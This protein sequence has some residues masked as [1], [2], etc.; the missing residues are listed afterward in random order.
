MRFFLTGAT[1]YVGSRVLRRLSATG[2]QVKALVRPRAGGPQLENLPAV[3]YVT[4]DLR[5]RDAI[6]SSG[7]WSDAVI[8]T[9]AEHDGDMSG[10][11]AAFIAA[12]TEALSWSG[13]ALV[14]TSASVVYGDTGDAPREENGPIGSPL[15]SRAWR[16]EHDNRVESLISEGIRSSVIRPST[17]Y[18]YGEGIVRS[19]IEHA[20]HNGRA[21]YVDEGT[22][23]FSTVHI[24]DLIDAY[25]GV[26]EH[27][28]AAGVFNVAS[29]EILSR[30][31]FAELISDVLRSSIKPE[32]VTLSAAIAE[33]GELAAIGSINQ[34]L[35]ATKIKRCL[36]WHP[37]RP[38]LESEL[39]TGTYAN[40]TLASL[41]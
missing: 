19:R 23:L 38:T 40:L 6:V 20:A 17:V 10:A 22:K 12:I 29:S 33:Q 24:E 25:L 41:I 34:V 30:L 9:A 28:D 37:S 21:V 11:D 7:R 26:I 14:Y 18:G 4:A 15:P 5:N 2:H 13:K 8:H 31:R 32:S 39:L 36:A 3:Q 1:G 16:V 35:S 27:P